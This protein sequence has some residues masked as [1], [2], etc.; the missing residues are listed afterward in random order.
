MSFY[1]SFQ[2]FCLHRSKTRVTVATSRAI[3]G[4]QP[5][6]TSPGAHGLHKPGLL[7]FSAENTCTEFPSV[8]FRLYK[9]PPR[10][11]CYN[12][13]KSCPTCSTW[14]FSSALGMKWGLF[15]LCVYLITSYEP[16]CDSPLQL[17]LCVFQKKF[18]PIWLKINEFVRSLYK[19]K[20]KEVSVR[21]VAFPKAH[22]VYC[23][24]YKLFN[25]EE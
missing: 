12:L 1:S 17:I 10:V 19:K 16:E 20:K 2:L 9:H 14:A 23:A 22:S 8:M 18:L 13:T 21:W 5:T 15:I 11:E 6:I 4:S 3:I 25:L 24:I 7:S